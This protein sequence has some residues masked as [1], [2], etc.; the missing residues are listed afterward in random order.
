MPGAAI[1]QRIIAKLVIIACTGYLVMLAR[2][3]CG[4]CSECTGIG[5]WVL[6]LYMLL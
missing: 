1:G 6:L 3:V 2:Y 5:K 4:H